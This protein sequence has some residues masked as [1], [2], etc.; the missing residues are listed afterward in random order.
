MIKHPVNRLLN[1]T[2]LPIYLRIIQL[3]RST[4]VLRETYITVGFLTASGTSV[5]T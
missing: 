2:Y 3:L 1:T 4:E 5:T